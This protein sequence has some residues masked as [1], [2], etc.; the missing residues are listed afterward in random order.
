MAPFRRAVRHRPAA[1]QHSRQEARRAADHARRN[2]ERE[3]VSNLRHL[4]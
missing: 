2:V 4:R 1:Q 3:Y